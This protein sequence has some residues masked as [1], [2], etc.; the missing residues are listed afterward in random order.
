MCEVYVCHTDVPA[1]T[2]RW[3]LMKDVVGNSSVNITATHKMEFGGGV[4]NDQ[5]WS[6]LPPELPALPN[7]VDHY[8][9]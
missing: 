4:I 8:L 5:Q 1:P 7:L 3:F 9:L 6:M 2:E